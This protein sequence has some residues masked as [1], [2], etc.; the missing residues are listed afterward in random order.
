MV[1]L[2]VGADPLRRVRVGEVDGDVG[3]LA[4]QRLGQRPQQLLAAGDQDQLHP[5]LA[6]E[7]LRGRL[8]DPGRG[9]G[10]K[11]DAHCRNRIRPESP[12]GGVSEFLGPI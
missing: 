9:P 5:R 1:G 6:R 8:A 12:G 7:P 4:G 2:D 3:R 11:R 10:Y